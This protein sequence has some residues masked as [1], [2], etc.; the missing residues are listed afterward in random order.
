[1]FRERLACLARRACDDPNSRM[2][3]TVLRPILRDVQLADHA[4]AVIGLWRR[5]LRNAAGEDLPA[6]LRLG[7]LDNPVGVGRGVLLHPDDGT[8]PAGVI[9]LHPRRM[10]FGSR[11]VDVIGLADFAVEPAFRTLGPA[12][13]LM[14]RALAGAGGRFVYGLPNRNSAAVCKRAGLTQAGHLVRYARVVG[15]HHPRMQHWPWALR[16]LAS[17]ALAL[18]DLCR[19][20]LLRPRLR[21]VASDFDDATLA[22]LWQQRP[23]E[24]VLG[25]RS[26]AFL[27]WRYGLP[28]RGQWRL[29]RVE[30]STGRPV[31]QIIW[32]DVAGRAELGDFFSTEPARF[33]A[34]M[35]TAFCRTARDLGLHSVSLEFFGAPSVQQAVLAAGFRPRETPMPVVMAVTSGGEAL[36]TD[37]DCWYLTSFDNDAN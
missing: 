17:V 9:G 11:Q 13:M 2:N 10:V 7:Y 3:A 32:R 33:T 23:Q 25:D 28:D 34:P 36:P 4:P 8:E 27:V 16:P 37:A 35:L 14:K 1:M 5:N 30:D 22:T 21:C 6:K 24:F 20:L 29:H 26:P 19:G 12:L 18:I 31:G 15:G